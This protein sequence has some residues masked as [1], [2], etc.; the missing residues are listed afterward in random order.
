MAAFERLVEPFSGNRASTTIGIDVTT[1]AGKAFIVNGIIPHLTVYP[2]VG[3]TAMGFI[4]GNYKVD[5]YDKTVNVTVVYGADRC[6]VDKLP[7]IPSS[8]TITAM[9][10]IYF[11]KSG[12][13]FKG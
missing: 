13:R 10:K 3:A 4:Y 7:S 9:D 8:A 6:E 5:D 12:L 1:T 2:A 11:F